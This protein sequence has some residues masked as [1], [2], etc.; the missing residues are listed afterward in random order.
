MESLNPHWFPPCNKFPYCAH[1]YSVMFSK[2]NHF[3]MTSDC[4]DHPID[5]SEKSNFWVILTINYRYLNFLLPLLNRIYLV[6]KKDIK[7]LGTCIDHLEFSYLC[8]HI[9][10]YQFLNLFRHYIWKTKTHL[11][12]GKHVR[13]NN[14]FLIYD[15]SWILL[16]F[17]S[18]YSR[19]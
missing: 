5:H 13:L 11:V 17:S 1:P 4:F 3:W 2:R 7:R 6:L 10:N 15:W 8:F 16:N 9:F 19:D 12:K 18:R 14:I